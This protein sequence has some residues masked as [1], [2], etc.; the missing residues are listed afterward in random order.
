LTS[1]LPS[2]RLAHL[3][4]DDGREPLAHVV[5]GERVQSALLEE[6]RLAR[7]VVDAARERGLEAREVRAALVGVDVVDEGE[8]VLVVP[9]V[10]LQGDLDLGFGARG[11]DVDH[12]LVQ[13]LAAAAQV[14]HELAETALVVVVVAPHLAALFG[15]GALVREGDAHALVQERQLA[16]AVAERIERVGGL[17]EDLRIGLEADRGAAFGRGA[18]DLQLLGLVA[19]AEGDLVHLAVAAHLHAQPLAQRVHH[20]NAHAVQAAGHLVRALAL[21]V[22][23]AA[24]VQNGERQ[25]HG[26]HLFRGVQVHGN[27][28]AV[29]HHG[30][31]VVGVDGDVHLVGVAGQRL[32]DG[33][34]HHLVDEVVQAARAGGAD[35]HARALADRLQALEDLDLASV[36]VLSLCAVR[37]HGLCLLPGSVADV[38]SVALRAVHHTPNAPRKFSG[39]NGFLP[40]SGADLRIF[41]AAVPRPSSIPRQWH[42]AAMMIPGMA[43]SRRT[44]RRRSG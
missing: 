12:V 9:V 6:P 23:L 41:R 3:H 24:R 20:R 26:R 39:R 36:V 42:G 40:V 14:L 30:D 21:V 7:V 38:R 5:A 43:F 1:L 8:R 29:V 22:E 33:V 25:L 10:V 17:L 31:A 32:V 2:L 34:V 27:A 19:A 15:G 37:R 18:D 13:R 28:A 11:L 4:A 35:V 16:E 44:S